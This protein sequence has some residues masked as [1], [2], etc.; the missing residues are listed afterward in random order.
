MQAAESQS[1][2]TPYLAKLQLNWNISVM[3]NDLNADNAWLVAL[4]AAMLKLHRKV[5]LLNQAA[6]TTRVPITFMIAP[7]H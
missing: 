6:L 5:T 3:R 1:M 7:E 4:G 2:G